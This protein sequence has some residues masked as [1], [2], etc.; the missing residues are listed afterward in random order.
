MTVNFPVAPGHW[1]EVQASVDLQNWTTIYQTD[2]E[3]ANDVEQFSDPDTAL[4]P[5]RFYRIVLH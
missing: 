3:S 2:V 1:Y 4:Y 5:S